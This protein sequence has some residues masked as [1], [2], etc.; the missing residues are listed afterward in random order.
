MAK[1]YQVKPGFLFKNPDAVTLV[2]RPGGK[3]SVALSGKE[4][5]VQID[6]DKTS[7]PMTKRI[8]GATQDDLKYLFEIE[9]HPFIEE[10]ED[11]SAAVKP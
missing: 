2:K 9:K 4:I 11:T 3:V 6:G 10:V 8:P 5:T 1:K 7:P